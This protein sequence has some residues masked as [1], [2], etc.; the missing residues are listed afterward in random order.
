[1]YIDKVLLFSKTRKEHIRHPTLVFEKLKCYGLIFNKDKCIFDVKEIVFL[2]H[3]VNPE[4][5]APLAS[6]VTA[7]QNFPRPS[8]VKR[9]RR[10][11]DMLNY[12][13]RFIP[14]AA[15]TLQPLNRMLSPRKYSPQTLH[16]NEKAEEAFSAIKT[17]L[18]SATLIV[19]PVLGTKTQVVVDASTSAAGGVLLQVIDGHAKPLAS[20]LRLFNSAQV[21]YS[22]FN[23]ELLAMYLS[24]RHF[25]YFCE[26][27]AFTDHKPLVSAV[28]SPVKQATARQLR[29]LSYVARLTGKNNVVADCLSRP[30][31]LNALWH[32]VQAVD[33]AAMSRAQQIDDSIITLLRT[34]HS[35]KIVRESVPGYDQPLLGDISKQVFRPLVPVGFQ[36]K[37]FTSIHCMVACFVTFRSPG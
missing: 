25:R 14:A 36:K 27:R 20:F 4:R 8:N 30:S 29:Q 16:W 5:V 9:L 19:F 26:G 23:R 18:A 33:F 35:L 31:D 34:D 15:A 28:I 10:F 17:K 12:Y 1:M 11:S 6:K 22:V 21:N 3:E 7:I 32:E 37:I 2:G 13:R 24:L